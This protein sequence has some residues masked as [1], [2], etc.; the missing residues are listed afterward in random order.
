MSVDPVANLR[1]NIAPEH[2]AE[3]IS[4]REAEII[5][6]PPRIPPLKPEE[7]TPELRVITDNLQRAAGLVPNGAVAEFIATML[8]YPAL[9]QAHTDLALVVMQGT[10]SPRDR[11]LA[12]LRTGWLLQA[13]YEW[14]AHVNIGK[15]LA[16]M[17][18]EEI[19]R[20]TIGS[21]APGWSDDDRAVLQAAEELFADAMISD[22]TWTA[23]ARRL[24]QKQLLELPVLIGQYTGVAYVQNSIRARLMPG[25]IGLR[26][27]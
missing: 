4:A 27:R 17:S 9:H 10:L 16:G 24:D 1:P 21:T 19:E 8:R 13:P 22:A 11:E 26:A 20:I 5:G 2:G 23:L 6:K 14:N 3:R 15:R 25:D 18:S 7:F 12:I